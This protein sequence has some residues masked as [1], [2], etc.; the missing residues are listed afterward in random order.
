MRTKLPGMISN[1]D[2]TVF[3]KAAESDARSKDRN[4]EY[5]DK[6]AATKAIEIGDKVFLKDEK[7][8]K[9]EGNF[10]ADEQT[11]V[12]KQGSEIIVVDENRKRIRRNS[13][14][15]NVMPK[16]SENKSSADAPA[17]QVQLTDCFTLLPLDRGSTRHCQPPQRYGDG[18]VY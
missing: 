13:T 2:P 8:G 1:P 18:R 4:G 17:L 12:A 11:V 5:G 14:F 6:S 15:A 16:Q 10:D 7:M 3:Q 9:L